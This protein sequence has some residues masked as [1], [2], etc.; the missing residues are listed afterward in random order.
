[1]SYFINYMFV[2]NLVTY[3]IER[4]MMA[5]ETIRLLALLL[6]L[7]YLIEDKKIAA[8]LSCRINFLNADFS[9]ISKLNT[10]KTWDIVEEHQWDKAFV[11]S[12]KED[13]NYNWV[14]AYLWADLRCYES[15]YASSISGN[16]FNVL[17]GDEFVLYVDKEL[18]QNKALD[19]IKIELSSGCDY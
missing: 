14:N 1:M 10:A 8:I 18:E 7:C 6:G 16:I 19:K 2:S 4:Y 3:A 13:N 9:W 17:M 15:V 11:L 12:S 5:M